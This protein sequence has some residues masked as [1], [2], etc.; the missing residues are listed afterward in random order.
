MPVPDSSIFNTLR[1]LN[2]KPRLTQR[3]M[4]RELGVSV[5][6]TN[7]CLQ[8][9]LAK[10]FVKIQNF[11]QNSN[12]RGYVYLITPEGLAAKA[13]LTHHFLARKREE[14]DALRLEVARLEKESV[15][16]DKL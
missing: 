8:A 10:G 3:E 11:R 6:K 1:L 5:G 12:K 14:Y 7:Y 2:E 4:A 13:R 15:A 16:V 9:L